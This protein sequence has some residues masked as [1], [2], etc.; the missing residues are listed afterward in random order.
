MARE[1]IADN[2]P[3]DF[4]IKRAKE[5]IRTLDP[6]IRKNMEMI[7]KQEVAVSQLEE[8]LERVDEQ[9]ARSKGDIQRLTGDLNRGSSTFVY[10]GRSYSEQQVRTDLT[11][12]FERHKT[13]E[14]TADKL[15]KILNARETGLQAAKEKL[16]EMQA[17]KRQLEVEVAN[18]EA[19]LELVQV[20]QTASEINFD[21][22]HLSRT[23]ELVQSISTRIGVA[24]KLVN[25]DTSAVDQIQ[26]DEPQS[27]D[28]VEEITRH[29]GDANPGSDSIVLH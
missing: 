19:R 15:R 24:E 8:Q 27:K 22:S 14:A 9:L 2:V 16:Q 1:T 26:L 28:I 7:A 12:R 29:F 13:Q 3:I 4:E 11:R 18:L 21:D 5:M 10:A 25:A 23:K 6:E 20:A 17:A